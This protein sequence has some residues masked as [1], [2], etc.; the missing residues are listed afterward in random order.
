MKGKINKPHGLIVEEWAAVDRCLSRLAFYALCF[1]LGLVAGYMLADY[2][3]F[4]LG[5]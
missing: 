5:D 1:I 3:P 4:L 2:V